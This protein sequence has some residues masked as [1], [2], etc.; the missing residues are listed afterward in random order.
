MTEL[1][2]SC[3]DCTRNTYC[4]LEYTISEA[5]RPAG[6]GG[7]F[8]DYDEPSP[9]K[10]Q[11]VLVALKEACTEFESRKEREKCQKRSESSP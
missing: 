5:L 10:Y 4:V 1:P 2:E 9:T 7:A 3:F 6:P 8:L 11:Y